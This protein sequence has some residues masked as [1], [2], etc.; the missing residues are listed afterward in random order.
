MAKGCKDCEPGSKRPTPHP[1]PRCA[2][3]HRAFKRQQKANNHD[4]MVVKVYGLLPGEYERM[5]EEQGGVCFICRRANG[6]TKRLAVDH[7][8]DTG[9]VRGLLCGPC[10]K[11]VG[12]VR[13]SADAFRRGAAYL[14]WAEIKNG[15]TSAA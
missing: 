5:Y 15:A 9:L 4:R 13:N 7:D 1:G 12:Y 2:T 14:D 3:H 10:N 8:H 6:R 11:F